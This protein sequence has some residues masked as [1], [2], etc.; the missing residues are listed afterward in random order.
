MVRSLAERLTLID[1]RDEGIVFDASERAKYYLLSA[2]NGRQLRLSASAYWLFISLRRGADVNGIALAHARGGGQATTDQL[3]RSCEE[4]VKAFERA[5]SGSARPHGPYWLSGVLIPARAVALISGY[6]TWVYSAWAAAALVGLSLVSLAM[7]HGQWL[8]PWH[9]PMTIS[10]Y[11]W[12]VLSIV[13]H[14]FG[15]AS[16]CA[17]FGIAPGDIGV[18][19]YL[20]VPALYSDVTSAWTLE[21]W[22]R[23]VVDLGGNYFQAFVLVALIITSRITGAG[24]LRAAAFMVTLS[25]L[26]SMN[27]I[28]KFDGYWFCA[29][30][31][32]VANLS[33]QPLRVLSIWFRTLMGH[34]ARPLPW[35]RHISALVGAYTLVSCCVW[36][37]CIYRIAPTL[38]PAL[39]SYAQHVQDAT[40]AFRYASVDRWSRVS[41]LL[42]STMLIGFTLVV[43]VRLLRM[44]L[45]AMG[46]AS[47]GKASR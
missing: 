45:R 28:F 7:V 5:E 40:F 33:Q 10:P 16:A 46:I 43:I 36:P 47:L 39:G 24:S 30:A 34:Q 38:G 41:T 22:K 35:P 11:A 6:L 42:G 44:A 3:A 12:L 23:V 2:P 4:L 37:A 21:R 17:R 32:G 18:T 15:H 1:V 20:M 14:E 25:I 8:R 26:V 31:L 19:M 27:P 13:V 29:D 9:Y